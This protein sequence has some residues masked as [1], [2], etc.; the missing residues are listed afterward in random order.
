MNMP[1]SKIYQAVRSAP[2]ALAFSA[3]LGVAFAIGHHV[4][5]NS[6]DDKAIPNSQYNVL[7]TYSISEQQ[8]NLAA[9]NVFAFITKYWLSL[10]VSTA[11]QQIVWRKLRQNSHAIGTVDNI[12][13]ILSNGLLCFSPALWKSFTNAMLIAVFFW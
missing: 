10:A 13:D 8:I 2:I 3:S 9:G 12:L 1:D 7:G 6:L 4:F 5:Y 11:F